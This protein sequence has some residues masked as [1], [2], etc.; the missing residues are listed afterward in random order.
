MYAPAPPRSKKTDITRSRS[1]CARCRQKRRKCD[2]G[3]PSCSRCVAATADCEYGGITLKFREATRWAA[4]KVQLGKA[5]TSVAAATS[6]ALAPPLPPGLSDTIVSSSDESAVSPVHEQALPPQNIQATPAECYQDMSPAS[7]LDE[8]NDYGQSP[9]GVPEL[10][11]EADP[12]PISVSAVDPPTGSQGSM[13]GSLLESFYSPKWPGAQLGQLGFDLTSSTVDMDD[14]LFTNL[15]D[16]PNNLADVGMSEPYWN[17]IV[18]QSGIGNSP[19]SSLHQELTSTD[20]HGDGHID[21][22]CQPMILDHPP[23]PLDQQLSSPMSSRQNHQSSKANT[24]QGSPLPVVQLPWPKA[25]KPPPGSKISVGHRIYLAHFKVAVTQAFPLELPFLWD[26]VI[27]SEPVRYAALS[28]SAA[29]LANLQGQKPDKGR[30]TLVHSAS[31]TA[32]SR[33]TVE[34]LEGDSVVSLDARL[35]TMILVVFY[36]LEAS[37]FSS[38]FHSLSILNVMIL[39]C[40]EDVLSLINGRI[41]VRWWLYL[42]TLITGAQGP[43]SLYGPENPTES[44]INQLEARVAETRQMIDLITTKAM[45]IWNRVLVAKCFEAPGDRPVDTMRKV[46]D[47]WRILKGNHLCEP[48][49]DDQISDRL[50][51]AD[52]LYEELDK[53]RKV[54]DGCDAPEGFQPAMLEERAISGEVVPLHF[55]NHRQAKEV[56]DF[57]LSHI[58]CNQERLRALA[59]HSADLPRQ[60]PDKTSETT[61]AMDPWVYLLLRTVAGLDV[62]KCGKENTY[63]RGIVSSIFYTGLFYPGQV[64]T[65]FINDTVE[66]MIDARM[67]FENPFY[68]LRAFL[69]FHRS[70]LGQ[71]A[72]G[73]TVFFACSTHDEWTTKETLLATGEEHLMIV[74]CES[75]GQY[76]NDL[77]P[78]TK[79]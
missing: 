65:E 73:R 19:T 58:I 67:E 61:T 46:D 9:V 55:N 63:R 16:F 18:M 78:F 74:G 24:S 64:S 1:G 43:Y 27:K 56:V 6:L 2:E 31:A 57:A 45:R 7:F 53:L 21:S 37:S 5:T 28:L 38:A 22:T 40:P 25:Q 15:L 48:A 30:G 14:A 50:L 71:V 11:L 54:L 66:R 41:I 33:Q 62:S 44:L 10:G 20:T 76:F 3:K 77:V 34:A 51:G 4:Q 72:G 29:N 35:V 52:E 79:A 32:F 26:M 60:F 69:D 8:Q 39:N 13:P 42:C 23:Q 70:L 17:D 47:W 68:P 49:S 36:E 12:S 75:D 59:E